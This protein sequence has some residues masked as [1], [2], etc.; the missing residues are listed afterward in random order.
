MSPD[1]LGLELSRSKWS[2]A[3]SGPPDRPF[4]LKLVPL[5][6]ALERTQYMQKIRPKGERDAYERRGYQTAIR[7]IARNLNLNRIVC[8][9]SMSLLKFFQVKHPTLSSSSTCASN[10]TLDLTR[11]PFQVTAG[12]EAGQLLARSAVVSPP[13]PTLKEGKG[14]GDQRP[15]SWLCTVSSSVFW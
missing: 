5:A 2:L 1:L 13:D 7:L 9:E 14:S 10:T 15:H 11:L 6:R 8:Q 12:F 3:T 4:P